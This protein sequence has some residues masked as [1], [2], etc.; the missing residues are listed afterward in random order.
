MR[1]T[2]SCCAR[3]PSGAA[4][5]T[6]ATPPMKV[7]RSITES[8]RHRIGVHGFYASGRA[9]PELANDQFWPKSIDQRLLWSVMR[10]GR[11]W[12]IQDICLRPQSTHNGSPR[13]I[14]ADGA[15]HDSPE[16]SV[17]CR[18]RR[19]QSKRHPHERALFARS[20]RCPGGGQGA[21][22]AARCHE[23]DV[24]RVRTGPLFQGRGLS[25]SVLKR[26]SCAGM[27]CA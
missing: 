26:T 27:T 19:V 9:S 16:R 13:R 24:Q 20:D 3:A 21:P 4:R 25:G 6:P 5:R 17:S 11:S 1:R 23:P 14:K 22:G 8:P 15:T 18:A 7:R 12:P 10:Y 2:R